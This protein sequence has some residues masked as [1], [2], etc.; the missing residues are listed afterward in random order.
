M[1][2]HDDHTARDAD[3]ADD[4]AFWARF[5][6]VTEAAL[7][8]LEEHDMAARVAWCQATGQHGIQVEDA[9][10]SGED[11]RLVWGGRTLCTVSRSVFAP[12][13]ADEKIAVLRLPT[14]PDDLSGL[15]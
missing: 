12:E 10:A 13:A 5:A 11:V 15:Q 1:S 3:A 2:E 8:Q 4:A 6:A 7:A 9:D 14:V